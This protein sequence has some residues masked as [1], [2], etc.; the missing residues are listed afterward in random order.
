MKKQRLSILGLVVILFFLSACGADGDKK[1]I[2]IGY[3]KQAIML[4]LKNSEELQ[5]ELKDLG[6][7][8]TW[9]EFSTGSSIIEALNSGSIDFANAGDMPSLFALAKGSDFQFIASE[10]SAPES[11]GILVGKDSGITSLSDLKGKKVAYNNASI[12]QY[13]LVKALATV[14]L[15]LEDITPVILTP[16]DASIAFEKGEV[17]AWVVWDPYMTV[18]ESNGHKILQTGAGIVP[19]RSFYLSSE[20]MVTEHP[21]LVEVIVKYLGEIGREIDEDPKDATRL[22]EKLSKVPADT[23]EISLKRK[24]TDIKFMDE[25]AVKDLETQAQDLLDIGLIE[26]KINFEGKIWYPE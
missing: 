13:L 2:K 14:D 7:T 15:T 12:A 23:W 20:K 26:N 25:E 21:E 11:E 24:R 19:L 6:Y 9:S 22:M 18:A 16:P 8:I 3:Q 4:T 5:K 17:D 1:E 10:A